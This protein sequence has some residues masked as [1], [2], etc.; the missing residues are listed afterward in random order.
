MS[1]A[2]RKFNVV[3]KKV[4]GIIANSKVL[5]FISAIV[6]LTPSIEIEPFFITKLLKPSGI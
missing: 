6:K 3:F 5:S 1:A 4:C 2:F